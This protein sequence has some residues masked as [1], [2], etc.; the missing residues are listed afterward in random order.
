MLFAILSQGWPLIVVAAALGLIIGSFLNVV[1]YRT[2]LVLERRWKTECQEYLELETAKEEPTEHFSIVWPGSSCTVCNTPIKAWQ[3]IPVISYLL[4]RGKC[5]SCDAKISI[6]YPL[7]EI[8]TAILTV[9]VALKFGLNWVGLGAMVLTWSLIAL[10]GIDFD[11]QLLPDSIC[12]P[13]LWLG[14]I[15]NSFGVYTH[16]LDALWGA[17]AGYMILWSVFW[18]FKLV[19]GKEGMGYG[20]FKLLAALGAWMG[21]QLLPMIILIASVTGLLAAI[22]MMIFLSHDRRVPIAFG[23]YL[24]AGGWLSFMYSHQLASAIPFLAVF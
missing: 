24:A 3:N 4:L 18:V 10:T 13:L 17:I 5:A 11:T 7:V 1:I 20:D 23:P 8:F 15:A 16:L 12:L 14:L 19:T 6:R 9:L 22:L 21:W 2:P